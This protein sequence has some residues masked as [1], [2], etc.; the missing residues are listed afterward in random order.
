[1]SRLLT[2]CLLLAFLSPAWAEDPLLFK[3]YMKVEKAI[4]RCKNEACYRRVLM[5][6]GSE[7]TRNLI[8]KS[9]DAFVKQTFE[10]EKK[11]AM[12]R[13][14]RGRY[15]VVEKMVEDDKAWLRIASKTYRALNETIYFVK[16][17]G[18]W[19]LG[20]KGEKEKESDKDLKKNDGGKDVVSTP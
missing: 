13:I 15:Y 11:K 5:K 6:Y 4:S 7:D 3:F 12:K 10:I 14:E 9:T 2:I 17:E 1:M 16:E 18:K 8:S 20:K 19:K